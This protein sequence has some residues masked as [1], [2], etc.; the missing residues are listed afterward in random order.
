MR[1]NKEC[2]LGSLSRHS[3]TPHALEC[4]NHHAS[5]P[6]ACSNPNIN[7]RTFFRATSSIVVHQKHLTLKLAITY[8]YPDGFCT[9]VL[10]HIRTE[11]FLRFPQAQPGLRPRKRKGS[12]LQQEFQTIPL[13][14]AKN[15]SV[16][17]ANI[18]SDTV[19]RRLEKGVHRITSQRPQQRLFLLP[20]ERLPVSLQD[21]ITVDLRVV[22]LRYT[23]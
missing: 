16:L 17:L 3:K 2:E 13:T 7:P 12:D 5:R 23:T 10:E 18:K 20:T 8:P 4:P 15:V 9:L 1:G 21:T 19:W 6:G 11:D 22:R 14:K